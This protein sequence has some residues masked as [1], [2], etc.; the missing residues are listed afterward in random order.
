MDVRPEPCPERQPEMASHLEDEEGE[1]ER[2]TEPE[3]PPEVD[4]LRAGSGRRG[5]QHGLERHPADGAVPRG[6]ADD[7][8]AHRARVPRA[9]GDRVRFGAGTE[10]LLRIGLEARPAPL[11]AEEERLS[12]VPCEA[13]R[14]GAIDTHPAHRVVRLEIAGGGGG[15]LAAA[16][17]GAE[18]IP[19]PPV[20]ELWR[21]R[22]GRD[23]H[24]ADGI[25]VEGLGGGLGERLH[26]A[27]GQG[28]EALP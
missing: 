10:K 13:P 5:G 17:F 21:I 24:S 25:P 9:L 15:E 1:S 4:E 18:A 12:R 2:G 28:G 16:R 26:P 23:L 14:R 11:G 19:S 8:R 27:L 20:V 3:A 6:V 22:R 7:L